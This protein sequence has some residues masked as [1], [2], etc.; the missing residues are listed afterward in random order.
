MNKTIEIIRV[1]FQILNSSDYCEETPLFRA[2]M[3]RDLDC[4]RLLLEAGASLD[5][6]LSD[7]T[8]VLH[9]A[10]EINCPALLEEFIRRDQ[11]F[12]LKLINQTELNGMT[13]LHVACL[14]G[15]NPCVERL[16][17]AGCDIGLKMT[18][19][20]YKDC[21][22]LHLASSEG[23][24][25]VVETLLKHNSEREVVEARDGRGCTPLHL[26]C[27]NGHRECIKKLLLS[28]ADLSAKTYRSKRTAI[29][30]LLNKVFQPIAF[31]EEVLDAH[32]KINDFPLS[33]PQCVITVD[34]RILEPLKKGTKQ[35]KVLD[36]LFDTGIIC[37]QEALVLHPV[38]E[39][40][41]FL[42]W[43]SL[44]LTFYYSFVTY[45]IFLLCFNIFVVSRYYQKDNDLEVSRVLSDDYFGLAVLVTLLRLFVIVSKLQETSTKHF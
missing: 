42:K 36:A 3:S 1:L 25:N 20:S 34:Y 6:T 31:L 21:T 4:V 18:F 22:A 2:V 8:T 5:H 11:N 29:S 30:I 39:S 43:L 24:F 12:K 32:I 27:Q 13:P 7:K 37:N 33:D 44:R 45:V 15:N 17:S 41:L 23:H 35:M 16:L 26:A 19:K 9:R 38:V 14:A 28:G 10:A 40:F